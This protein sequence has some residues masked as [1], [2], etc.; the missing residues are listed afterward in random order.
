M[1]AKDRIIVALDVNSAHQ[2]VPYVQQLAGHVGGFK[3]SFQLIYSMLA[4]LVTSRALEESDVVRKIKQFFKLVAG[5][6]FL[7]VKLKDIPNTVAGAV[8]AIA[9]MN[10][11]MFN[12]HCSGGVAMMRAAAEALRSAECDAKI[13]GV[14]VLTSLDHADFVRMGLL[15]KRSEENPE[16]QELA[17]RLE[18][19]S[20][21]VGFAVQA[22]EAGLHGVIASAKEAQLIRQECG[23]EFLIVTPG[24]RPVFADVG[25]QKRVTTPADAI[26]AG[27]DY[28]VI[29]RPILD[30]PLDKGGPAEAAR[31]IAVEMEQALAKKV[32]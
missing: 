17:E 13:L 12:L 26:R 10:P 32:S 31:L 11:L 28:L 15:P 19:E 24:I 4:D 18:M 5:A 30:Y 22:K 25:D 16:A 27:A 3:I 14:T 7:D 2:A 8:K 9:Q 23:P 29:G 1:D 21:V 20:L 6:V